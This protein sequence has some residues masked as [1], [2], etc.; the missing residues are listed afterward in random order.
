M[1]KAAIVGFGGISKTHKRGYDA[2]E[3]QNKVRLVAAYDID[4]EAF[5]RTT[6]TNLDSSGQK[7]DYNINFYTNLEQMLEEEKPDF[8]DICAPT[9]CHTELAVEI[10]QMGY[11]VL[12]EKPM[13]ITYEQTQKMI[14][15]EKKSGKHLMVAQCLRFWK[16]YM[17]LKECVDDQRYGKVISAFFSRLSV[18]PT[19]GTNNWFMDYTKSG[20]CITDLHIH[21]I[22]IIR[23]IFGEPEKV[24][25]RTG[26]G[27]SKYDIAHTVLYYG[28]LPITAVGDWSLEKVPFSA[29]YRV[30]FEKATLIYESGKLTV[31]PKDENE[32]FCPEIEGYDGYASEIS[33]FCD[34]VS[35]KIDNTR[36]PACSAAKTISLIETMKKSAENGGRIEEFS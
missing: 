13:A 25:C 7:V 14:E 1:L 28:D 34:V 6:Q 29:T 31:Y 20:G 22:D 26:D 33:Y 18:P 24:S 10:L 32:P 19:W 4:P 17:Y 36:N 8:I 5:T 30:G 12:C 15:A 35:G 11:N 9:Y 3:K 23:C 27:K 2:L 16:E 21:D